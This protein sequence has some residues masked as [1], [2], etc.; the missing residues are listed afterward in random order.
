MTEEKDLSGPWPLHLINILF[1]ITLVG[2]RGWELPQGLPKDDQGWGW[3]LGQRQS[4]P[5]GLWQ[6]YGWV[7][8]G[9][10][11]QGSPISGNQ[12]SP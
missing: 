6:D 10:G 9:W 3:W 12:T 7:K 4:T 1:Q 11:E 5:E 8:S 2:S